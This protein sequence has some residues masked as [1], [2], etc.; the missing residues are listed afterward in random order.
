MISLDSNVSSAYKSFQVRA[1][2]KQLCGGFIRTL[3]RVRASFVGAVILLLVLGVHAQSQ[4]SA[5]PPANTQMQPQVLSGVRPTVDQVLSAGLWRVDRSFQSSIQVNNRHIFQHRT[6]IPVLYMADG[7]EY[8]LPTVDVAPNS[9]ATI[10][11]N[12]AIENAPP[13]VSSHLSLYGSASIHFLAP[14]TGSISAAIQILDVANSLNFVYAFHA[15]DRMDAEQHTFD[16]LWWHRDAGVTGFVGLANRTPVSVQVS[17]QVIGAGGAAI[18]PQTIVLPGH[19]TQLLSLDDIAA[20]L[21]RNQSLMGGLHVVFTGKSSD[22][23]I[24]G[25]LENQSEGYSALIPFVMHDAA[26]DAPSSMTLAS[27]G[28]MVGLPDPTMKF[29]KGTAFFPYTYL[30]NASS[31]SMQVNR[32]L[33]YTLAGGGGQRVAL[34]SLAI[35]AG[36]TVQVPLDFG[37]IGLG[38]FNGQITETFST[39]S[40]P[41]DLLAATGSTDQTANYVFEVLPQFVTTT[42]S[43]QSEYWHVGNSYDTMT[44]VW[45]SGTAA[46]DLLITF[47]FSGGKGNYKLPVHLAPGAA[48]VIDMAELIAEAKPDAEGSL[49]PSSTRGG[50][51]IVSGPSDLMD[52]INVI[53]SEGTFSVF[54]ATCVPVCYSCGPTLEGFALAPVP[55][56]SPIGATTQLVATVTV[57]TGTKLTETAST[58]WSSLDTTIA[59]VATGGMVTAVAAGTTTIDGVIDWADETRTCYPI[60]CESLLYEGQAPVTVQIPTFFTPTAAG[61]L[62]NTFCAANSAYYAFVDYQV[63]D[64]FGDPIQVSGMT[65]LES[66]STNGGSFSAFASFATPVSTGADGA[67]EDIPVG[68]CFSVPAPP[69]LC[70]PVVQHFQLTMPGVVTPY[71]ISTVTS[72]TDCEQGIQITIN[73]PAPPPVPAV[74]YTFG[75]LK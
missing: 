64:Q 41:G 9:L 62:L 5:S 51:M 55:I 61:A 38:S 17:V 63:S 42:K 19:S 15:P 74:T 44:T 3:P 30:R 66:V 52:E 46:E 4:T 20:T 28:M 7:T 68:T 32:A 22:V 70:I 40:N 65:P 60:A 47:S 57:S 24:S 18:A 37:S 34:P 54:G 23:M 31:S 36:S 67:F 6:V 2:V 1:K 69:N 48:T 49:I 13:Q 12:S 50:G 58:K 39:V 16:G 45:N 33:Y 43:L 8:Y 27:T 59:S 35:G 11:I 26:T 56:Q 14:T 25:G 10:S 71:R 72:R 29:P 73:P 75:T 21:P 53:L